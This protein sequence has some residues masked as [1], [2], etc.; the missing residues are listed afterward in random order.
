M[1]GVSTARYAIRDKDFTVTRLYM[2]EYILAHTAEIKAKIPKEYIDQHIDVVTWSAT[3]RN[4][5]VNL[6]KETEKIKNTF[7]ESVALESLENSDIILH[8][9]SDKKDIEGFLLGEIYNNKITQDTFINISYMYVAGGANV[10]KQL[11]RKLIEASKEL[12]VKKLYANSVY[13]SQIKFY[14]DLGFDF[15]FEEGNDCIIDMNIGFI[16]SLPAALPAKNGS[17]TNLRRMADV[18]VVVVMKADAGANYSS[19]DHPMQEQFMMET[20]IIDDAQFNKAKEDIKA[21]AD[22][23]KEV[24]AGMNKEYLERRLSPENEENNLI[25]YI[26]K[27][28]NSIHGFALTKFNKGDGNSDE[29]NI[30]LD[31][32][33]GGSGL[34]GAGEM[35]IK[36]LNVIALANNIKKIELGSL[37]GAY[38]FYRKYGFCYK[39]VPEKKMYAMKY[40]IK[41]ANSVGGRRKS[42]RANRRRS[43]K[44]RKNRR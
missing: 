26:K 17:Q 11:L 32:L 44:T 4:E 34:K 14:E 35:I 24:C 5:P 36:A 2:R 38:A 21:Y 22:S 30:V 23:S 20:V 12:H 40:D 16:R 7:I 1:A 37:P 39:S 25:L 42:R 33:C 13:K 19:P 41:D 31:I 28:D 9:E 8:V 18:S 27:A 29:S 10:Q 6:V 3:L 43:K 15:E